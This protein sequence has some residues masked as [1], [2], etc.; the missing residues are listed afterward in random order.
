MCSKVVYAFSSQVPVCCVCAPCWLY[1]RSTCTC[2]GER[3]NGAIALQQDRRR[4]KGA[5]RERLHNRRVT[6][7]L[8]RSRCMCCEYKANKEH[9][10]SR[11]ELA[12]KTHTQPL[13]T[14]PS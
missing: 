7:T 2:T 1:I 8:R 10:H 6:A 12:T 13:S 5:C 3:Y 14:L 11:P 9:I 4:L